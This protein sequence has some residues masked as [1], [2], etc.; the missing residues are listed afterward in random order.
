MISEKESGKNDASVTSPTYSPFFSSSESSDVPSDPPTPS[1]PSVSPSKSGNPSDPSKDQPEPTTLFDSSDLSG[2]SPFLPA[3]APFALYDTSLFKNS[4]VTSISF[5][6]YGLANGYTEDSVGLYMPVYVVNT[7]F[8]T[9]KADCTVENGKKIL[10]D[11]TGKMKNVKTGDWLTVDDLS[12]TVGENETLAFGDAD[13]AVLPGFLRDDPSHGFWNR[14]FGNKGQNKHSLVFRIEGIKTGTGTD[15]HISDGKTACSIMGDSIST[16]SGWSNNSAYNPTIGRNALWFPNTLYAGADMPVT[17]TWWYK[18]IENLGYGI[19]VNNSW[20]G[21]CVLDAQTYNVRAKNLHNA[22]GRT[23]DVVIIF[24]GVND[25][26]AGNPLG[27]YD[28][29]SVPSA[30]PSTFSDA[31]GR[32][33][34]NIRESYKDAKIYC[35][36]FL[37]DGK[38]FSNAFN[39]NGDSVSDFN[40]VIKTVAKNTGA[41]IIDLYADSGITADNLSAYTVDHLHPNASGMAKIAA[42]VRAKIEGQG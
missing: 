20:S 28:G 1:Q 38:R 15:I 35:C 13:M 37:P 2:S 14:I 7:D 17:S 5:P 39:K 12:I 10:L 9:K 8:S 41:T 11:F 16:Y 30:T 19:C 40:D 26:A 34:Y 24:M 6:F 42:T 31:Y 3:Y 27:N 29:T 36:T 33:I 21:S 32:M 25:F 4:T 18:T 23:P 22:E